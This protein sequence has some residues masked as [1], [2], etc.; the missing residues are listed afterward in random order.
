MLP[1]HWVV[2][3]WLAGYLLGLPAGQQ[4]CTNVNA[5]C[6]RLAGACGDIL[7]MHALLGKYL[8]AVDVE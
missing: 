4:S 2:T 7:S 3:G 5:W 8:T 6:E 1:M